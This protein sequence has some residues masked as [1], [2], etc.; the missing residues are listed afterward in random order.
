MVKE[1]EIVAAS[2]K[3]ELIIDKISEL[4]LFL[5]NMQEMYIKD[6]KFTDHNRLLDLLY[7]ADYESKHIDLTE[8][9]HNF[10]I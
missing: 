9:K 1:N 7:H 2:N 4:V 3:K 5:N 10:Y 8:K 6:I